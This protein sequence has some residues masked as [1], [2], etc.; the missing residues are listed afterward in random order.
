MNYNFVFWDIK[1]LPFILVDRDVTV[2]MN[3]KEMVNISEYLDARKKL[4]VLIHGWNAKS[5]H[6][7][8]QPVKDAYLK[9][10]KFL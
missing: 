2:P 5:D 4:K 3:I 6:I 1:D 9:Y 7:A 8:M 10:F